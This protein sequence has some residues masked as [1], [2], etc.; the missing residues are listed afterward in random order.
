MPYYRFN[1]SGLSIEERLDR[2]AMLQA[3]FRTW[4][5]QATGMKMDASVCWIRTQADIPQ[6]FFQNLRE[7]VGFDCTRTTNEPTSA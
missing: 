3:H 4:N 5:V 1:P 6:G 7:H 2:L